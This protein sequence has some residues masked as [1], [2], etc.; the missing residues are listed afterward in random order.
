VNWVQPST[1]LPVPATSRTCDI[2]AAAEL[3]ITP[4][5]MA[6]ATKIGT[7]SSQ[8]GAP[9]TASTRNVSVPASCTFRQAR[10]TRRGSV[11]SMIRLETKPVAIRPHALMPKQTP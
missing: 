10:T 7:G 4:P 3:P 5:F 6:T 11:R 8:V 9:E 2:A 1:A